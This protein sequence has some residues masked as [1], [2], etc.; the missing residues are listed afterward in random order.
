MYLLLILIHLL[1]QNW[2]PPGHWGEETSVEQLVLPIQC[3]KAA[4]EV[5]HRIPLAGHSGRDKTSNQISTGTP[6]IL[7]ESWKT[8][9]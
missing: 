3:R 8:R 6:D 1:Y 9:S 4:L 5:A 2:K 7:K